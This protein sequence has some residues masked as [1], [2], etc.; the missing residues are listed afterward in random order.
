MWLR[1]TDPLSWRQNIGLFDLNGI[2]QKKFPLWIRANFVAVSPDGKMIA[3]RG[4]GGLPPSNGHLQ[5]DRGLLFGRLDDP[6]FHKIYSLPEEGD[7]RGSAGDKPP[8]TFAWSRD[9]TEIVYGKDGTIYAYNLVRDASRPLAKGSNPLWSPEGTW[10]SY[11]GP[12][13]EAM[14]VD[15]AGKKSQLLLPGKKIAYALHWSPDGHYLLLTLLSQETG[16]SW[17]QTA[18]YRLRDG[19]TTSIGKPGI[20]GDDSGKEWV[21]TGPLN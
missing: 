3:F 2:E 19:A 17:L 14:L 8:E 16:V 9:A 4:Q 6:V 12:D 10:I 7:P 13:G 1:P 20:A 11:R 5:L 15:P 21:L 18:V